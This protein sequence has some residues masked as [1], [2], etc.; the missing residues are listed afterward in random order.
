MACSRRH[1]IQCLMTSDSQP[2]SPGVNPASQ[3]L[4]STSHGPGPG[5]PPAV[6]SSYHRR[7]SMVGEM[8]RSSSGRCSSG[9]GGVKSVSTSA[10]GRRR[11]TATASRVHGSS[12]AALAAATRTP[13]LIG[14]VNHRKKSLPDIMPFDN[15]RALPTGL[16]RKA[17]ALEVCVWKLVSDFHSDHSHIIR[18]N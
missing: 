3:G 5:P 11:K 17:S 1:S 6:R 12:I 7:L 18:W 16:Q 4:V 10:V 15:V 9:D 13:L 8:P 2:S 14:A